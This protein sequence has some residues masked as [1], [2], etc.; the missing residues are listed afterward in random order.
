MSN[1][2]NKWK[3]YFDGFCSKSQEVGIG[4]VVECP[5][6]EENCYHKDLRHKLT[7]NQAEYVALIIR[8]EIAK[9]KRVTHL[10]IKGDSKLVCKQVEGDWKVRADNLKEFHHT[11]ESLRFQFTSTKILHVPR[12][13]N[14]KACQMST[15]RPKNA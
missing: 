8:L 13:E 12:R 1:E 4:V 5:R 9:Q 11:V 7:C 2:R 14:T 6:N 15:V 10:I 3:L